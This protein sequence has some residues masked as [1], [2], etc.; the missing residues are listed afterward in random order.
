MATDGK[1]RGATHLVLALPGTSRRLVGL[2]QPVSRRI[3]RLL[4]QARSK[5]RFGAREPEYRHDNSYAVR[6]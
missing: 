1:R 6:P 4:A 3:P 5:V 2:L